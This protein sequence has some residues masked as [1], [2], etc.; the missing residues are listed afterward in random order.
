[1][2]NRA[3]SWSAC[4]NLGSLRALAGCRKV[5]QVSIPVAPPLI[6]PGERSVARDAP[7]GLFDSGVGGL[8]V[9]REIHE[10]LPAESL[11][12]L[13]DSAYAPYGGRGAAEIR[14]RAMRITEA[15]VA[16]GVKAVV[17]ACN[18]ATAVAAE[19]LRA[20]FTVPIVGMEPAIK[21]AAAVSRSGVIGVLA[22]Q[23]TLAS[24]RFAGLLGRYAH[25]QQIITQPCPGLVEAVEAGRLDHPATGRLLDRYLAP[26]LK[27]GADTIILGCTH[28]PF[29]AAQIRQRVPASTR[30][31]DTG[32]AVAREL[33]RRLRA[34]ELLLPAGAGR[35]TA[36][37]SG[38]VEDMR[39][40]LERQ[41]IPATVL[42]SAD[43]AGGFTAL[44][45]CRV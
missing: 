33:Q 15:L 2:P 27:A 26:V 28:Y 41:G 10:L 34:R 6:D 16:R 11:L 45:L 12:Y 21:P 29:L 1:M 5:R 9:L 7:V 3:R 30:L 42:D 8:S 14:A 20:S 36:A 37:T 23:G 39:R 44:P 4:R 38:R 17:I 24:A 22:T 25:G 35:V 32:P 18:T 43:G 40:F 13:A 31:I 19:Q